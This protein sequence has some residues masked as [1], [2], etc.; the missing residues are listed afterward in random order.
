MKKQ[1]IYITTFLALVFVQS[2]CTDEFIELEPKVNQVE[3]NFYKTEADAL[4]SVAAVYDALTVQVWLHIPTL[5]DVFSDDTYTGGDPGAGGFDDWQQMEMTTGMVINNEAAFNLWNRCYSGI[6]RA[7]LYL[8]KQEDIKWTTDGLKDRLAA[9]VKFLRAY[10][11]WD[12]ARHYASVPI[13]LEVLPNVED[14]KN[15]S[16]SAPE[17]VYAQVKS[18]LLDAIAVL[19]TELTPADAGRVSK[20]AAQALMA[21]VHMF[22]EGYGKGVLGLSDNLFVKSDVID[23]LDEI[24][25][26]GKF[27][28]LDDYAD[29]FDWNNQN[30]EESLFEW[31]YSDKAKSGDWDGWNVNG[32][33]SVLWIG[34][35]EAKAGAV[36]FPESWSFS[37]PTWS[38]IN[39]FETDDPRKEA[40]LFN[41]EEE[42]TAYTK[43]FQN[44]GYFNK[45]Y[46]GFPEFKP[47]EGAGEWKHN[48]DRNHV[49]MRLAE[50]LLMAAELNI[51]KDDTKALGY[52]NEVRTRAMG[53][54]AALDVITLD[55]VFHEKRVELALEGHRKWD[56]LRRGIAFAKDKIAESYNVPDGIPN[57]SEFTAIR[58]L[59]EDTKGLFPIPASEIRNTNE[60]VLKQ[61]VY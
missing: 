20:Y 55:A 27:R 29:V 14:Y 13:I 52:L 37:I 35:R 53:D 1:F 50:V 49:D 11:Y 57:A 23:A 60:G 9:E 61:Y 38:L 2:A 32:N 4:L 30:N 48:W 22:Y 42:L 40:T 21:R 36:S 39:E 41:A 59:R 44:T 10:F 47:T 24:I 17:A 58:G 56:I 15:V 54:D 7:N 5:S 43:G 45:K 16:Q 46:M 33:F 34:P 18:D 19:P 8:Q 6:Y 28:L 12:L 25:G 51:G 3:A 31:Q 26:S